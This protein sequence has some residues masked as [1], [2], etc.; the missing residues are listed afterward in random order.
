MRKNDLPF[1]I[2]FVLY[3]SAKG[4]MECS[5]LHPGCMEEISLEGITH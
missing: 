3:I 2:I 5:L 4:S 1:H